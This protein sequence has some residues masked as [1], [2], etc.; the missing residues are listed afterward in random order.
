M[1]HEQRKHWIKLPAILALCAVIVV[2]S[3][4]TIQHFSH[5]KGLEDIQKQ[6]VTEL[7]RYEG[8]YDTQSIVLQNTNSG[9]AKSLANKL[10][11]KLRITSDGSFA[12]LT[13]PEGVTVA[14]VYR[15]EE[16]RELLD[17]F[18]LDLYASIS[19]TEDEGV[20]THPAVS[21][22]FDLS[23]SLYSHQSYLNYL[24]MEDV[25]NNYQGNGITV[26]VIDS[27]IDTDHPEFAGKISEYSYNA[28][29]DKIVKDY[30]NDWSLIE[31]VQGHGTS[32]A[33]VIAAA[34]DG[35]GIVG[36]APNVTLI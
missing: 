4:F 16:Y 27:G 13:L 11:A 17:K 14:D 5:E 21:P 2:A 3:V 33:G 23:D 8:Q 24:H 15:N 9:T 12:T 36:I 19:D 28:T 18:S 25:W 29:E 34:M 6:A 10:G 26:A 20:D 31:D 1:T 35:E 22:K 7:E 32:V 30:D